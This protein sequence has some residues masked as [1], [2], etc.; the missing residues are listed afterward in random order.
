MLEIFFMRFFR[1]AKWLSVAACFSWS[2][3]RPPFYA[4]LS[5]LREGLVRF[6][7]FTKIIRVYEREHTVVVL[8]REEELG[9]D[10]LDAHGIIIHLGIH[11]NAQLELTI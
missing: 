9:L 4:L 1:G 8:I 11:S 7:S 10:G 2:V 6:V 5:S 3:E